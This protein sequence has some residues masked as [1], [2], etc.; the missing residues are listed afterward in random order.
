MDDGVEAVE[1]LP[2]EN[3]IEFS[4]EVEGPV[5]QSIEVIRDKDAGVPLLP[6]LGVSEPSVVVCE[7]KPAGVDENGLDEG[8]VRNQ[9]LPEVVNEVGSLPERV[10]EDLDCR[11][12]EGLPLG[13]SEAA[14]S[15]VEWGLPQP[16]SEVNAVDERGLDWKDVPERLHEPER[17]PE[18]VRKTPPPVEVP[19]N[20]SLRSPRAVRR[21]DIPVSDE[22]IDVARGKG[23]F[24]L[25][26]WSN[27]VVLTRQID[28]PV[29]LLVRVAKGRRRLE[30]GLEAR[31]LTAPN[32]LV[33][34]AYSDVTGRRKDRAVDRSD[35]LVMTDDDE[36]LRAPGEKRSHEPWQELSF[37]MALDEVNDSQASGPPF[38]NR[39]MP[40]GCLEYSHISFAEDR[41]SLLPVTFLLPDE[42]DLDA[43]RRL[44]PDQAARELQRGE[45]A[46]VLQ[47]YLR[48]VRAGYQ[49]TLSGEIPTEGLVVFHANHKRVVRRAWKRLGTTILVG[50]R[51]DHREIME[52]DFEVLQ[53]G[54]HHD[55]SQRFNIAH[56]PQPGLVPRDLARGDRL[57]VA[58]YKGVEA[59]LAPPFRSQE[60]R[61][62][63]AS[64]GVSWRHDAV[65]YSRESEEAYDVQWDTYANVD[66]VLAVR[67]RE[68][69]LHASKPASKLVNAWR[70]GVPALLGAEW[71]YREIRKGDL[72]FLEVE[73]LPEARDAVLRLHRDHG[74]YRS[75]VENGLR[76]AEEFR[77][78]RIVEIWGHLLYETIPARVRNLRRRLSIARGARWLRRVLPGRPAN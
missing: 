16:G 46:W 69:R 14:E 7:T 35:A 12:G 13:S 74:L 22:A 56:W 42:T 65:A 27:R 70:A 32:R 8:F 43:L 37:P 17:K 44:D 3:R 58:C 72:D 76:R 26:H 30:V 38:S 62:F 11:P 36:R 21:Q 5:S 68:R 54:R 49:A 9:A 63:L 53:N 15:V 39:M 31:E 40:R 60:W 57:E 73:S 28:E 2:A 24:D 34:R 51:G 67:P 61:S 20:C 47:T 71:A 1:E 19:T 59:N 41:S 64:L 29:E 18:P 66:L 77:Y 48:L 52:A 25:R 6:L 23:P 55:G 75:M 10:D 4:G 33:P 45:R 50:I 78:D